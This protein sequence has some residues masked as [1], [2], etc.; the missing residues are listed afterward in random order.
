MFSQC[1]F[2]VDRVLPVQLVHE[3]DFGAVAVCSWQLSICARCE[4][5]V[6]DRNQ[7]LFKREEH[8]PR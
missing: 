2:F 5:L 8:Y 4:P 1:P 7:R 6:P 3:Q